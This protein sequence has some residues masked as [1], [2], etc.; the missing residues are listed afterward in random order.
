MP[1]VREKKKTGET[2]DENNKRQRLIRYYLKRG[3]LKNM[4]VV[5]ML[6]TLC[7]CVGS[8]TKYRYLPVTW[9]L[10]P[11]VEAGAVVR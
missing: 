1:L 8:A 5:H 10:G 7:V 4:R 11:P 9:L 3:K 2:T 6:L